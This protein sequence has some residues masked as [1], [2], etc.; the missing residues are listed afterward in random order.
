LWL[1][2]GDLNFKQAEFRETLDIKFDECLFLPGGDIAFNNTRFPEKGSLMWQRCYFSVKDDKKIDFSECVFRHTLFSGGPIEWMKEIKEQQ[3]DEN[4][5][6]LPV[7]L[8]NQLEKKYDSLPQEVRQ[9]IEAFEKPFPEF[10]KIF[11]DNSAVLW[12]DL[13]TES[14]KHLTFLNTNLSRSLFNGMTLS[15]IQ[16]NACHWQEGDN[17]KPQLYYERTLSEPVSESELRQLE[18]QYTQLKSNL[19]RQGS[20]LQAGYFHRGEQE[21]RQKIRWRK[22]NYALWFFGALYGLFS[23]FGE[24]PM[25]TVLMTLASIFLLTA[26][27]LSTPD[28]L[29]P[30]KNQAAIKNK[31]ALKSKI[32]GKAKTQ[33]VNNTSNKTKLQVE[34]TP[35]PSESPTSVFKTFVQ[36]VSPFSWKS[37][38][39]HTAFTSANVWRYAVFFI[40]QVFIL[41]IQIPLTVMTVRR[42][43]KR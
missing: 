26:F 2:N 23:D 36:T 20:Y 1:Q 14:A 29:G 16:L 30:V 42:H 8:K 25:R 10:S 6:S 11:S 43:F 22:K 13:T 34:G 17:Q 9:R 5:R 12:L 24:S 7:I 27:N 33:A 39:D 38:V 37:I 31:I 18:D 41:A 32:P 4:V 19:E 40:W 15:H 3:A 28:F 21:T 35:T